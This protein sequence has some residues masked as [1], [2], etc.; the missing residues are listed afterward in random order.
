MPINVAKKI[1]DVRQIFNSFN[2]TLIHYIPLPIILAII[3]KIISDRILNFS[4]AIILMIIY[5]AIDL[6]VIKKDSEIAIILK[7]LLKSR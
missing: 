4:L 2:K 5:V 1:I 6:F 3:N 7:K